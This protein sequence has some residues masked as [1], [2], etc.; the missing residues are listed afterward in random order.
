LEPIAKKDIVVF[1]EAKISFGK[2]P[3]CDTRQST[4]W[5]LSGRYFCA[6]I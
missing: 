2:P 6:E 4:N 3:T 1:D 5:Y